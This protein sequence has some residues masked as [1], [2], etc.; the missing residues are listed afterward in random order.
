MKRYLYTFLLLLAAQ[1]CSSGDER[2]LHSEVRQA[3]EGYYTHLLSREYEEFVKG[4]HATD[5]IPADYRAQLVKALQEFQENET[6]ARKGLIRFQVTGDSLLE[7]SVNAFVYIDLFF[8][9]QSK[10]KTLV[11]MVLTQEGWKMK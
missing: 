7:D 4:M 6:D 1:A 11:P 9:D 10:E 5:S 3:A 8:G 2:D